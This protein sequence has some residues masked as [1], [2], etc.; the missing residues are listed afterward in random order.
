MKL[1]LFGE[2]TDGVAQFY[3]TIRIE[4]YVGSVKAVR[5]D[6]AV[7]GSR[8][9]YAIRLKGNVKDCLFVLKNSWKGF[10][11]HLVIG[12]PIKSGGA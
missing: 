8:P 2:L 12:W 1:T 5:L 11:T 3:E 9:S 10:P 7:I 6:R 4:G